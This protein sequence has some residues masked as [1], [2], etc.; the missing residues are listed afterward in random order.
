MTADFTRAFLL[1]VAH[2]KGFYGEFDWSKWD[3]LTFEDL[4]TYE[5]C[6]LILVF[7]KHIFIV[8][9]IFLGGY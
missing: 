8:I 3:E 4:A 5:V 1:Q 9:F 2:D 7:L 6:W